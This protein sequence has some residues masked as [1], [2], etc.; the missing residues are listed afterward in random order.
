M[1][2]LDV[3]REVYTNLSSSSTLPSHHHHQHQQH[4]PLHSLPPV[5]DGGGGGAGGESLDDAVSFDAMG[6]SRRGREQSGSGVKPE[7]RTLRERPP[8]ST[9]GL[10][11]GG[12]GRK[13]KRARDDRSGDTSYFE[14]SEELMSEVLP[15]ALESRFATA[16]FELGLRHSSPKVLMKLMPNT[17]KLTTEHIKSHLQKYR[18][19]YAR[20]KDE[21]LEF[22]ELRLKEKFGTFCAGHMWRNLPPHLAD[23]D[24]AE[25]DMEEQ[26]GGLLDWQNMAELQEL[27]AQV[28][29]E[30]MQ[31]QQ[32]LQGHIM[33]QVKLQRQLQDQVSAG[34]AKDS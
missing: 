7:P 4:A 31:L 6:G 23:E 10:R 30:Q 27:S 16:V 3:L 25:E 32:V 20:S 33:A 18:L 11:S 15:D 34:L 12:T 22:F 5:D 14:W 8:A 19:H 17:E 9:A 24:A 13:R 1:S 29:R 2:V 28:V 26:L 21:F